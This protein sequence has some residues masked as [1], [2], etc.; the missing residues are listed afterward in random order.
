MTTPVF[1]RV[2]K[3]FDIFNRVHITSFEEK[4]VSVDL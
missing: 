4:I 1:Q 3:E 2:E